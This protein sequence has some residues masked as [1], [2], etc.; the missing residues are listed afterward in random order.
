LRPSPWLA[1]AFGLLV[2]A[3][4]AAN[5]AMFFLTFFSYASSGAGLVP[6]HHGRLGGRLR[7]A[8]PTADGLITWAAPGLEAGASRS[9]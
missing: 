1:A 2:S 5:S 6:R 9:S 7:P 4:E 8:V 3:P